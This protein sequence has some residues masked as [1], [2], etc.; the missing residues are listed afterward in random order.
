MRTR[1]IDS[2]VLAFVPAL[3]GGECARRGFGI[4]TFATL[5]LLWACEVQATILSTTIDGYFPVS[6][7]AFSSGDSVSLIS[8]YDDTAVTNS[9]TARG[10]RGGGAK[11]SAL[12]K[13]KGRPRV[14]AALSIKTSPIA[15]NGGNG[16]I[17]DLCCALR[18]TNDSCVRQT[19]TPKLASHHDR[20]SPG[21][22][23]GANYS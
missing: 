12:R 22:S 3:L 4:A 9:L 2:L 11:R 16:A 17:V 18:A 8:N 5:C 6:G 14:V 1:W 13:Q 19:H 7:G 15:Q 10:G 23:V 21:E 20:P